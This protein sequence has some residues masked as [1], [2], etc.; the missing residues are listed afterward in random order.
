MIGQQI[1]RISNCYSP[2]HLPVKDCYLH[3]YLDECSWLYSQQA[4]LYCLSSSF[5]IFQGWH[6]S[7]CSGWF[8]LISIMAFNNVVKSRG[9]R[10]LVLFLPIIENTLSSAALLWGI[11]SKNK[12][13]LVT[14]SNFG[15]RCTHIMSALWYSFF[16]FVR[17]H[18]SCMSVY[19]LES[20]FLPWTSKSGTPPTSLRG[21]LIWLSKQFRK[22]ARISVRQSNE[23][24]CLR[25]DNFYTRCNLQVTILHNIHIH[26]TALRTVL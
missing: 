13:L 15:P 9:D 3:G 19:L 18:S 5:G 23:I 16:S 2:I 10:H 1:F 24:V 7:K 14:C 12:T 25:I 21:S 17:V 4:H 6:C 20:C 26:R 8:I 22:R 11:V